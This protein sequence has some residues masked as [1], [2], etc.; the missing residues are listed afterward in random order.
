[1]I[2]GSKKADDL[3][4]I[5]AEA[6]IF[7]KTKQSQLMHAHQ[8]AAVQILTK[9]DFNALLQAAGPDRMNAIKRLK[10]FIERERLKGVAKHWSYDL[11]RH[12]AL[13]QAL[14]RLKSITI[15]AT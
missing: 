2:S 15:E 5:K 14:E 1:M 13:K 10:R 9:M 6:A 7:A 3:L 4:S 8:Q 12:I 11:N